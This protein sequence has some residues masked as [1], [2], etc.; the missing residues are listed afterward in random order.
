MERGGEVR[1][2]ECRIHDTGYRVQ[3]TESIDD[4]NQGRRE[5]AQRGVQ[6]TG[7]RVQNTECRK[8]PNGN[9]RHLRNLRLRSKRIRNLRSRSK[10]VRNLRLEIPLLL[11][12]VDRCPSVVSSGFSVGV[13][14]RRWAV[15]TPESALRDPVLFEH[16]PCGRSNPAA[17]PPRINQMGSTLVSSINSSP[18]SARTPAGMV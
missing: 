4:S 2:V 6:S 12:G 8:N 13:G 15:S 17:P 11:V 5:E 10:Q 18:A 3:R 14:L 9:L 7:Y 1:G 16:H